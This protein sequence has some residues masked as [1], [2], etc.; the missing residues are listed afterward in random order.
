M[1]YKKGLEQPLVKQHDPT[2]VVLQDRAV[3][4]PRSSALQRRV[5]HIV[6]KALRFAY[7]IEDKCSWR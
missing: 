7:K 4:V 5:A 3:S 2:E 1:Q 6:L